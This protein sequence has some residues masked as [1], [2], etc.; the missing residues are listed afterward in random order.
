MT[1]KVVHTKDGRTLYKDL[2]TGHWVPKD[3]AVAYLEQQ[4]KSDHNRA[5]KQ[6]EDLKAE[7]IRKQQEEAKRL[8]GQSLNVGGFEHKYTTTASDNKKPVAEWHNPKSG[9]TIRAQQH[10]DFISDY[11]S[12]AIKR[13]TYLI[14]DENGTPI[15]KKTFDGERFEDHLKDMADTANEYYKRRTD[16]EPYKDILGPKKKVNPAEALMKCNREDTIN[17]HYNDKIEAPL[18]SK[19]R[20]AEYK[21]YH[22]N[23]ALCSTAG[24]L[25]AQGYDVEAM[26]RDEKWRGP[27]TVF[28]IDY[29]NTDNF[30]SNTSRYGSTGSVKA[31]ESHYGDG[32]Y[33]LHGGKKITGVQVMPK[34]AKAVS[35]AVMEKVK[36]WGDGAVGEMSVWWKNTGSRHSVLIFNHNGNVFIFD[37][38]SNKIKPD[39]EKFFSDTYAQ[40]TYLVRYDNAPLK[41]D[42]AENLKK[43]VKKVDRSLNASFERASKD[44]DWDKF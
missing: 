5:V 44:I 10:E 23:C 36:G 27:S 7:Q 17:P 9:W 34:G 25:Q 18:G 31:I 29:S 20:K 22:H 40:R 38:Q 43:M 21:K 28:D 4:K 11:S 14:R 42:A 8:N 33:I 12:K 24:I 16:P 37:G 32:Y 2:D 15:V 13:V 6:D 35:K 19:L 39:L 3:K 26:P 30:I 41:K 1:L